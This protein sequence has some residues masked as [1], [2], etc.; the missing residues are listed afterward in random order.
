M[1][2]KIMS[3][4]EEEQRW[5]EFVDDYDSKAHPSAMMPDGCYTCKVGKRWSEADNMKLIEMV[6]PG[7]TLEDMA[8]ELNRSFNGIAGRLQ[9]MG[10]I[11]LQHPGQYYNMFWSDRVRKST[12]RY[13]YKSSKKICFDVESFMEENWERLGWKKSDKFFLPPIGVRG[14]PVKKGH[15]NPS[16]RKRTE[17]ER[18]RIKK[19]SMARKK[20]EAIERNQRERERKIRI[21]QASPVCKG[22]GTLDR[23]YIGQK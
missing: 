5:Q 18:N 7:V 4:I 1:P 20:Y 11:T 21:R 10:I 19:E 8:R 15:F 2:K 16:W 9:L 13:R 14:T 23:R 6:Q 22:D 17:P 3:D 12:L